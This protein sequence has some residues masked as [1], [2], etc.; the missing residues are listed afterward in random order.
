MTETINVR[1][2][3]G[4]PRPRKRQALEYA[5]LV[6]DRT[7]WPEALTIYE[8]KRSGPK[9]LVPFK[10]F[11]VGLIYYAVRFGKERVP[12]KGIA[13]ELHALSAE[14]KASLGIHQLGIIQGIDYHQVW[15]TFDI[16]RKVLDRQTCFGEEWVHPET[17]E[18]LAMRDEANIPYSGLDAFIHELIRASI[19]EAQPAPVGLALDGTAIETYFTVKRDGPGSDDA[20]QGKPD[21][22]RRKP[23]DKIWFNA[24][25]PVP[26]D[27][28]DARWGHRTT[29]PTNQSEFYAGYEAHI[30]VDAWPKGTIEAPRV[31]RG[32]LLAPAGTTRAIAGLTL[33][34][35]VAQACANQHPEGAAPNAGYPENLYV[36]RGYSMHTAENWQLPLWQRGVNPTFDLADN[37]R[38]TRASPFD[39]TIYVD[40]GLYSDALPQT[41]K[42]KLP[43]PN[44]FNLD[45]EKL[46]ELTKKY[47]QRRAFAYSPHGAR[48]PENGHQ[49]WKGPATAGTVRCMNNPASMTLKETIP[50][51]NCEEG[52]PCG[53]SG[54]L[55][56][57]PDE[58]AR[59]SQWPPYQSSAW[60]KNYGARNAVESFNADARANISSWQK[61][62]TMVRTRGRTA[63]LLAGSV[64]GLNFHIVRNW[65]FKQRLQSPLDSE[66]WDYG[67]EPK[68]TR[69]RRTQTLS[70]R[71]DP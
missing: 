66:Q 52:E 2:L 40:G 35:L 15:R 60:R 24:D 4:P 57:T 23:G 38:T 62:Y 33:L 1:P 30:A 55:T 9:R 17:G 64:V 14:E 6:L 68:N 70:E 63:L 27:D 36:D 12:I 41:L 43:R 22:P 53:C 13:Q 8:Q 49:R 18:I 10:A 47:D 51:T 29:T 45:S 20:L 28:R 42:K 58:Y 67:A 16:L 69:Q 56:V 48:N 34:D 37:Q 25:R 61:G 7:P 44:P 39:D 31:A 59:E 65:H 54:T 26:T 46:K 71:L 21:K 5:M 19:P 50:L 3:N 11:V 32:F